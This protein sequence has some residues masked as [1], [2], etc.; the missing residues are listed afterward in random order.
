MDQYAPTDVGAPDEEDGADETY[1]TDNAS[2]T[3]IYVIIHLDKK[4]KLIGLGL[5]DSLRTVQYGY[6]QATQ[7]LD[8]HGQYVS[9]DRLKPGN[10]VTVGELD[11]EAKLTSIRLASQVWYQDKI[12]IRSV[13]ES[14]F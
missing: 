11:S 10:I 13:S 4:N 1:V 9:L 7:I 3:Q 8:E 6:T 14:F 5:P 2:D 12:Q